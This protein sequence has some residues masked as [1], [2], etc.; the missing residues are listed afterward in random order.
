GVT[1]EEVRNDEERIQTRVC[2]SADENVELYGD[3]FSSY[4]LYGEVFDMA[5]VHF[6]DDLLTTIFDRTLVFHKGA[7]DERDKYEKI[8]M[9]HLYSFY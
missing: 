1:I 3:V 6:K 2:R 8:E 5:I 4:E 7:D 9:N